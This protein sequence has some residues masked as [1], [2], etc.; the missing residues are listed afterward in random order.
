MLHTWE[1]IKQLAL[2]L[3]AD[4][5]FV[6]CSLSVWFLPAAAREERT[7]LR[8]TD[9]YLAGSIGTTTSFWVDFEPS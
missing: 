4:E 9:G 7:F 2:E 3:V 5:P 1:R 6:M 8:G